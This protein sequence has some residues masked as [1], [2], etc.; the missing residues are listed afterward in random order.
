MLYNICKVF[1]QVSKK[2]IEMIDKE[3][4]Q[5]TVDGMKEDGTPYTGKSFVTCGFLNDIC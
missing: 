4:L 5:R 1:H 2:D 3:I